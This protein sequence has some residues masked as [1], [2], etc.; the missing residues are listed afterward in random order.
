MLYNVTL[1]VIKTCVFLADFGPK[2]AKGGVLS[3]S[4]EPFAPWNKLFAMDS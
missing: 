3:P 4:R 2:M 1:A